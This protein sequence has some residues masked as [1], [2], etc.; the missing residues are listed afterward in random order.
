[1]I[2]Q[3]E[4]CQHLIGYKPNAETHRNIHKLIVSRIRK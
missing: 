1:M 3:A 2:G 4:Q